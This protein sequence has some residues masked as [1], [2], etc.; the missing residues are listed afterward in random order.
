MGPEIRI[1]LTP[2]ASRNTMASKNGISWLPRRARLVSVR[3]IVAGIVI[4]VM[5]GVSSSEGVEAH[6]ALRSAALP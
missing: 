3:S 5:G 1:E 4:V 6:V 2:V